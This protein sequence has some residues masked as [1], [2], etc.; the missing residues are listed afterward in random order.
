MAAVAAAPWI[1][2]DELWETEIELKPTRLRMNESNN[3]WEGFYESPNTKIGIRV[4]GV[5]NYSALK[6]VYD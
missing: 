5:L 6:A 2:F 1:L 4:Q 3:F